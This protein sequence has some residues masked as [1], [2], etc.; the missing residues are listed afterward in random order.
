MDRTFYTPTGI[1]T[2]ALMEG[3]AEMQLSTAGVFSESFVSGALQSY[4]LGTAIRNFS[5]PISPQ[6]AERAGVDAPKALTADE[7]K[8]SP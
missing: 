4:G 6:E 3:A 2:Q 1:D 7:Y 5:L 8:A